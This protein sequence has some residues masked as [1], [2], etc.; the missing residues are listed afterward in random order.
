MTANLGT[1]LMG[2]PSYNEKRKKAD[3]AAWAS[4]WL[5]QRLTLSRLPELHRRNR[6]AKRMQEEAFIIYHYVKHFYRERDISI[7]LRDGSQNFDAII[8]TENDSVLEYLEVTSVPQEDDH[9]L[10]HELADK[11]Q[12]SLVRMLTH[13]PSLAA[14]AD[15]VSETIHKKLV[16]I[17]P[18]PTTLLVALSSEM[19]VED[20]GRFD[21]VVSRIDPSIKAG[22]FSKLVLLDEPGTHYHTIS[23]GR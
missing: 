9:N 1:S 20:D 5:V 8:Y 16:K 23:A 17:Y 15:L 6:E 11:G 18:T 7:E 10:R 21:Y 12:Y 13:H 19:I 3:F 14:Y 22:K 2:V 4:Q